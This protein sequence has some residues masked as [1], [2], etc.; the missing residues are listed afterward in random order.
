MSQIAILTLRAIVLLIGVGAVIVQIALLFP[1]FTQTLAREQEF[2]FLPLPIAVLGIALAVCVEAALIAIWALLSMVRRYAIFTQRA[3][4]W[5]NVIIGAGIVATLLVGGF[6]IPL[7]G[8]GVRDDAPGVFVIVGG[9]VVAG[10]AFV[11]LM[12][13]MRGLLRNATAMQT[14]LS[15]VV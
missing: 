4:R 15:E 13:V 5:V 1:V 3:F 7:I 14:E 2:T 8:I 9:A 10:L 12:I 11:L 6:G